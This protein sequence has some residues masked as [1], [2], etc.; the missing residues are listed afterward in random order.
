MFLGAGESFSLE[1]TRPQWIKPCALGVFQE[2]YLLSKSEEQ[3][4][5][6]TM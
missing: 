3:G 6:V 4:I 5:V 2:A 1:G